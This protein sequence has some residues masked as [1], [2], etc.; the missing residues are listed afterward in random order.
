MDNDCR[1]SIKKTW[2]ESCVIGID[3]TSSYILLYLAMRY[4]FYSLLKGE[5]KL[6]KNTPKKTP[7][8]TRKTK[9]L[10]YSESMSPYVLL[11][12]KFTCHKTVIDFL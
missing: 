9:T 6:L 12:L 4:E 7:Q 8:K 1:L 3:T 2:M 11:I 5:K 10:H